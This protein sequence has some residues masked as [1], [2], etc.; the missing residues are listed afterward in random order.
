[1][2][3]HVQK[4]G[5]QNASNPS[6][7]TAHG[8]KLPLQRIMRPVR[9]VVLE[10]ARQQS[11]HM[12]KAQLLCGNALFHLDPPPDVPAEIIHWSDAEYLP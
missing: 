8:M 4:P 10:E 6:D 7:V 3:A 5:A 11:P 12:P 2:L 9:K 1:M